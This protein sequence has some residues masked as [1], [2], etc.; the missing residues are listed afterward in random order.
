MGK[1]YY[2]TKADVYSAPLMDKID[3]LLYINAKSCEQSLKNII[4]NKDYSLNDVKEKNLEIGPLVVG[5]AYFHEVNQYYDVIGF[6]VKSECEFKGSRLITHGFRSIYFGKCHDM[7]PV[8]FDEGTY[9]EP[10]GTI[11][12]GL[13]DRVEILEEL[14]NRGVKIA[15]VTLHVGLGT[16]R[17]VKVED[18]TEHK[19]HSEHYSV[20][21]EKTVTLLY[22]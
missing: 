6:L 4:R 9:L 14:K 13:G 12:N 21:K 5:E 10:C 15:Y 8:D 16:F 3:R 7:A 19:M 1:S 22:R 18:V 17:P 20:S 11:G 2:K